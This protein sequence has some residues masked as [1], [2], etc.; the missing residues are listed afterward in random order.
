MKQN[1]EYET[2]LEITNSDSTAAVVTVL[3]AEHVPDFA[4]SS[5]SE[6]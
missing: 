2:H 3:E 1:E 5:I 6:P 4:R